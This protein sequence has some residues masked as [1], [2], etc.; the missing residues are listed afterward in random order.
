MYDLKHIESPGATHVNRE[1]PRARY[2]PFRKGEL[3]GD[4]SL[5]N[6]YPERSPFYKSLNGDWHFKYYDSYREVPADF[7]WSHHPNIDKQFEL[8]SHR[9]P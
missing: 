3:N 9:D 8:H 1:P 4:L 5:L 6:L 2:I 7:D